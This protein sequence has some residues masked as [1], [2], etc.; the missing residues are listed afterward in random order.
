MQNKYSLLRRI[1]TNYG[2]IFKFNIFCAVM[3]LTDTD[4]KLLYYLDFNARSS[5]SQL[6]K[7]L[8]FSKKGIDY[9]IKKLE[10]FGIINKYIT[11]IN[12]F[13]LGYSM[14]KIFLSFS[15]ISSEKRKEFENFLLKN[16]NIGVVL[17]G[18]GDYDYGIAIWIKTAMEFK[19][20]LEYIR[21]KWNQYITDLTINQG[22][23]LVHLKNKH[24]FNT[25]DKQQIIMKITN[26]KIKIDDFD[27]KILKILDQN[28]RLNYLE[29]AKKLNTNAIKVSNRI[30][31]LINKKIILCFR[32]IPSYKKL[33][34]IYF[35]LLFNYASCNKN[36]LNKIMTY[37]HN[38]QNVVI[39]NENIGGSD[40]DVSCAFL[41]ANDIHNFLSDFKN[42][43]P[44]KLKDFKT[45]FF[46][47]I[48]KYS[49]CPF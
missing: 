7:K 9:K 16:K 44:G 46:G 14:Y 23:F 34:L 36:D 49:Y 32:T 39:T 3:N 28:A 40:I 41:R 2:N 21:L 35:K 4:K 13:K 37:L 11:I 47:E 5:F 45:V 18:Q 1:S 48:L 12:T 38:H 25:I 31:R 17:K 42:K 33:G 26:E 30:K 8:K 29:I 43:F 15:N 22:T 27:I 6:A 10:N 19:S 24:F 20:I